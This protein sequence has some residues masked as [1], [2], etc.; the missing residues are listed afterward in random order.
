MLKEL[1]PDTLTEVGAAD[2]AGGKVIQIR[3]ERD[4]AAKHMYTN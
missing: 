4:R 2:R 1:T 3:G